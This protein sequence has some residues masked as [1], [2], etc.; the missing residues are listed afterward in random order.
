MVS[1]KDQNQ[2]PIALDSFEVINLE[3][4]TDITVM[5]TSSEF[6]GAQEF[7][8]YPLIQ[9]GT[10][11][12]NQTQQIQFKGFIDNQEV[13]NSNYIV[14]ADCCHVGLDSGDLQLTL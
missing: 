13:I 8:Q 6:E 7:G 12:V 11:E 1:I 3:N 9:D 4:G 5:L 14:S 10:L 2:N